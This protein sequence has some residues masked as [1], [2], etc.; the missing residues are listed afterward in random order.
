M[1]T[2]NAA[3]TAIEPSDAWR[4]FELEPLSEKDLVRL[5]EMNYRCRQA[6]CGRHVEFLFSSSHR[7]SRTRK[8]YHTRLYICRGHAHEFA[9]L[10]GLEAPANE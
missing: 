3:P 1:E 4:R 8:A 2:H 9:I 7:A 6:G 10:H 5:N